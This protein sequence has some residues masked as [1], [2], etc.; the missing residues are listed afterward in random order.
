MA[1]SRMCPSLLG[2]GFTTQVC[3]LT[4][5]QTRSLTVCG[6]MLQ[7]AEPPSQGGKLEQFKWEALFLMFIFSD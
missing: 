7:T 4:G 1:A 3:A 5:N 6:M 2:M